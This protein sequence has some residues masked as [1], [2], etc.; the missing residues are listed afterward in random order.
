VVATYRS[1]D[2]HRRHPLRPFLAELDR[3]RTVRR[4]ELRR[5]TRDEA[6][7]QLT[8]ILGAEP[9]PD[10]LDQ[11]HARADGNPFF[12]EQLACCTGGL[13]PGSL[14]ESLR[15]LLLVRVEAL[16]ERAQRV[17]RLAA[18]GGSTV[19]Y[20]LL[21]AVAGLSE[22]DLLDALRLAVGANLLRPTEDGTGYRFRHA[23]VREAVG[24]DLLPGERTRINRRYAEALDADPGLVPADELASRL[25]GYWYHARDAARALP[26]ALRASAAA[27]A[28]HA[29]AAQYALLKGALELWEAAPEEVRGTLRPME[30]VTAYPDPAAGPGTPL[31]FLDLLA[32]T[33][34]AAQLGGDHESALDAAKQALRL[35]ERDGGRDGDPLRAAWFWVRRAR[36]MESLGRGDGWTEIARAQELVR[37]LP[38]SAVHAE[39]LEIAAG[40]GMMHQPGP[41]AIATAERAIEV[42]R[43]VGAEE[44]EIHARVSLGVLTADCGDEAGAIAELTAA[45]E[46]A[47]AHGSGRL[48][49]GADANLAAVLES[50]GRSAEAVEVARRGAEIAAR[51][52]LRDTEVFARANEAES[53]IALGRW[54]EAA[55]LAAHCRAR[56]QHA[57][58]QGWASSALAYLALL[59]GDT[60]EATAQTAAARRML[61]AAVAQPQ[62]AIPLRMLDIGLAA[63]NGHF[64]PA[65][66]LT[67]QALDEGF[68]PGLHRYAWPLLHLAA[69][70]EGDAVGLPAAAP[71][72]AA[73]LARLREAATRLPRLAPVWAAHA[74]LVDAELER[75]AGGTGPVAGWAAAEEAFAAV[76]RPYQ[77][78]VVRLRHAEALIANG[79]RA[80]AGRLLAAA[81]AAATKLGAAPLAAQVARLADRARLA[82]HPRHGSEPVHQAAPDEPFGLTAR[83]REVLHCVALGY[84]NRRIAQQLF[85]SPKT[86]SVHVSNIL[87]KLGVSGRGEA[88]ALAHRLRLFPSATA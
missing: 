64:L 56:S 54:D 61:G 38:P 69:S 80:A 35:L 73:T 27:R 32:E 62:N 87:A 79:D 10:V 49:G 88:A 46:R 41:A 43:L 82:L 31:G 9:E 29:Y 4:I 15:D 78:A 81:H 68:P 34:V 26:A 60:A 72:R 44:I 59:R 58:C 28:R 51:H 5:L 22:D 23:L 70:V 21:A 86:A 7:A 67:R 6:R 71:D 37:G 48:L 66:A 77:L 11:I 14:S 40:W 42:A 17:L 52:G 18:E 1:D 45:R 30:C 75:A 39:V 20:G 8:G 57:L 63:A 47:A 13:A 65:R 84:T 53:L 2:I 16:P 50:V 83:E 24:E 25:A 3:L 33:V 85:I 36:L 76:D 12:V 19:E 55:D 74:L